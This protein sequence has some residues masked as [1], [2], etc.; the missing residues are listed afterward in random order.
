MIDDTLVKADFSKIDDPKK[1]RAT[2]KT[3]VGRVESTEKILELIKKINDVFTSERVLT[4]V[5][6]LLFLITFLFVV[7]NFAFE[8]YGLEKIRAGTF[9]GAKKSIWEFIYLSIITISTTGFGDIYPTT[10]WGKFLVCV[11]IFTGICL[12]TLLVLIFTSTFFP[13]FKNTAIKINTLIKVEE[14]KVVEWK[15][16]LKKDIIEITPDKGK[17]EA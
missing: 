13:A 12:F 14:G 15:N 5:F 4:G 16:M 9:Y 1:K 11:E 8:F 7:F 17:E 3:T 6:V 10:G 2:I